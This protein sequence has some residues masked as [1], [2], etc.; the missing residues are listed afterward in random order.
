VDGDTGATWVGVS[1]LTLVPAFSP[2]IHDY[3]V[4]CMAGANSLTVSMRAPSGGSIDL[5]QPVVTAGSSSSSEE[6]ISVA[7]NDAIVVGVTVAGASDSYWIRCLPHDFPTLAV[8]RGDHTPAPAPGYYLVGGMI[9]VPGDGPYAIV[10]DSNGVPVWY[11]TTADGLDAMDVDSLT[12]GVISFVPDALL[13]FSSV[14]P[15]FELHDLATGQVSHVEP[16]GVPLDVH[17]LRVLPNGDYLVIANP[18]VPGVDLTG[19]AGYGPDEN[20]I[21]CVVQ[22]LSPAGAVVWQ[23]DAMDHF[24][25]VLD[26]TWPEPGSIDAGT[27]VDA[28]HCNSIDVA[29]DGDLLISGR[30]MDSVFFVSKATGAI[31]WKMGGSAYT[32]DGAPYI[33][34][35]GGPSSSFYRQHDARL[36]PDAGLTVFDDETDTPNPARAAMYSLDV[37]AQQA[38]LIWQL[39]A[40]ANSVA[41]GSFRVMPDGSRVIGWGAVTW[42][43]EGPSGPALSEVDATGQVL[44]ELTFPDGNA[45][46]RAIKVPTSELSIDRMRATAGSGP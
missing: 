5:L 10:V 30:D 1:P 45:S 16:V 24:D 32:K 43:P 7:E 37:A 35:A 36:L 2:A 44:F 22:E 6:T 26:S 14:G 17:E 21:D 25:P 4:R 18:V 41:M 13:S 34:V 40:A 28:F 27:F 20:V 39:A 31:L 9:G 42:S 38:S 23:W 19:L 12:P 8:T 29:P 33:A 15:Q 46:Y 3:Y 11:H